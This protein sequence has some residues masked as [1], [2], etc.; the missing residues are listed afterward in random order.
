[1]APRF[2]G[3]AALAAAFVLGVLA[4]PN[5]AR[6]ADAGQH[7]KQ[8]S[9]VHEP[10]ATS[11]TKIENVDAITK[12]GDKLALVGDPVSMVSVKVDRIAGDRSFWISNGDG[13]RAFV[14]VEA[15][16]LDKAAG[17][18][19][20]IKEGDV[21]AIEGVVQKLPGAK[22]KVK[23]TDWGDVHDQDAKALQSRD[24]YVYAKTVQVLAHPSE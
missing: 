17:T 14:V 13:T 23:V 12:A 24:V 21:V 7:A 10:R 15:P 18:G 3:C 6:A 16:S 19:R 2:A 5:T 8:T 9:Q 20:G 22:G 1:M 4:A 11:G